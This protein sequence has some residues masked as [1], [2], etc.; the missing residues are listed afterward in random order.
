[1]ARPSRGVPGACNT[2]PHGGRNAQLRRGRTDRGPVTPG[3]RSAV[4]DESFARSAQVLLRTHPLHQLRD[5]AGRQAWPAERSYDPLVLALAGLDAVIAR[6]GLPDEHN[7]DGLIE[8]LASLAAAAEPDAGPDEWAAVAEWV[9]RSLLGDGDLAGFVATWGDYRGGYQLSELRWRLLSER[10]RPD[11]AIVLEATTEAINALRSGLDLNVEDAQLARET[12]LSAQLARG[13]LRGA[14][15]SA[16]EALR[17]SVELTAKLRD[18]VDAAVLNLDTVDWEAGFQ[19]RVSSALDHV[20][21]R[22]QAEHDLLGHVVGGADV[23]DDDVR[24]TTRSIRGLLERCL[25]RH[26]GLHLLLQTAPRTFLDEQARQSLAARRS[27]RVRVEVGSGLLTP[28]LALEAGHATAV[29]VT[30]A[31][32]SL[33]VAPVKLLRLS[34][35]IDKL[36]RP[37][38]PAPEPAIEDDPWEDLVDDPDDDV[39]EIHLD[40]AAALLGRCASAPRRLSELIDAAPCPQTAEV[41]RLCALVLF[42]P[43]DIEFDP[44]D[45]TDVLARAG[46]SDLAATLTGDQFT[47]AG[48]RGNDLLVGTEL[49]LWGDVGDVEDTGSELVG[50]AP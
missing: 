25:E 36:L 16:E 22:I 14:E 49:A 15:A 18:L 24:A 13:D 31:Q 20:E 12:V 3:V 28:A 35:I 17:L 5:R 4:F 34:T 30:F 19:A 26:R 6:T 1:M 11:G 50:V 9:V 2:A 37:P 47:A 27:S 48:Y 42:D 43:D 32:A 29:G 41:L 45:A 44:A 8:V 7:F 21:S 39:A 46:V 23:D 40:A 33:G 10:M 38:R